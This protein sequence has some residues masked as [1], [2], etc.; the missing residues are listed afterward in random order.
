MDPTR[1][2]FSSLGHLPQ[3]EMIHPLEVPLHRSAGHRAWI[4][5]VDEGAPHNGL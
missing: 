5:M 3:G 1:G 4:S 2:Y